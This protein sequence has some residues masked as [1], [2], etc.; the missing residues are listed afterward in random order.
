MA[1]KSANK[2][3]PIFIFSA[4]ENNGNFAYLV[5]T[6]KRSQDFPAEFGK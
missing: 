3:A 4:E 6:R 5:T 1:E 2:I